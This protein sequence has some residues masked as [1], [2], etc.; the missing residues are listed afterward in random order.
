MSLGAS[1]NGRGAMQAQE[2]RARTTGR[3]YDEIA[4]ISLEVI[5]ERMRTRSYRPRQARVTDACFVSGEKKRHVGGE[6]PGYQAILKVEGAR[7]TTEVLL[8]KAGKEETIETKDGKTVTFVLEED[9]NVTAYILER[10]RADV[11]KIEPQVEGPAELEQVYEREQKP[12]TKTISL[13][14]LGKDGETAAIGDWN[15]CCTRGKKKSFEARAT[16]PDGEVKVV[17]LFPG[18]NRTL[19][20]DESKLKLQIV[21]RNLNVTVTKKETRQEPRTA[22][23]PATRQRENKP[24]APR[25][26]ETARPPTAR[27]ASEQEQTKRLTINKTEEVQLTPNCS[28]HFVQEIRERDPLTVV[29]SVSDNG[30]QKLMTIT[31]GKA[32]H[33]TTSDRAKV[34]LEASGNETT[35]GSATVTSKQ[36]TSIHNKEVQEKKK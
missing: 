20:A 31:S 2:T 16:N 9:G 35:A 3:K 6:N 18:N 26:T 12:E 19:E 13:A 25:T 32:M 7:N 28:V 30:D 21:G 27:P 10:G 22:R 29:F 15:V 11:R 24:Q 4:R 1:T 8:C 5:N 17:K 36:K 14:T 33:F 34:K 23:Q